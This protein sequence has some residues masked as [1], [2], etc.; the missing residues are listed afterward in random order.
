MLKVC[1]LMKINVVLIN[2][3]IIFL[4]SYRF[5]QELLKLSRK[6]NLKLSFCRDIF[7]FNLRIQSKI[8]CF[9]QFIRKIKST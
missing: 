5:V 6:I 3:V 9:S 1:S 8:V 4:L 2:F 7:D